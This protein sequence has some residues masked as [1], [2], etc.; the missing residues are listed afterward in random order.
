MIQ[1]APQVQYPSKWQLL[2]QMMVHWV[3]ADPLSTEDFKF[4]SQPEASP[5]NSVTSEFWWGQIATLLN[6]DVYFLC[7]IKS[8]KAANDHLLWCVES[9]LLHEIKW[10]YTGAKDLTGNSLLWLF[11]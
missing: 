9:Q 7:W 5:F 1:I 11:F 4:V 8:L 10:K 2:A 6:Q 3:G